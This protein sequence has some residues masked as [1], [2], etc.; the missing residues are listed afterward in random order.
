MIATDEQA[1]ICDLA[2]TYHIYDY[3]SLPASLVAT[4]SFGLR[5]DSRIKQKLAGV[6]TSDTN[7][8]LAI[9]AD[10]LGG[11][12]AA[13]GGKKPP[14]SITEDYFVNEKK[15]NKEDALVFESSTAF[16]DAWS[17]AVKGVD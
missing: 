9:I 5:D 6:K 12:I 7:I 2:E 14:K 10:R 4:F 3:R 17:R 8:L 1:L 16:D 15:E 11:L 13:M